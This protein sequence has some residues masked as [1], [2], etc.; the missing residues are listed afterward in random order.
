MYHAV[1]HRPER[2]HPR[3]VG[4]PGRVR[5]ADGGCS[6]SAASP[7]S[8]PPSSAAVWR[9]RRAA[10]RAA[11]P[12]HLRRRLR[13]RAP[14]R[15][16]RARQ[17]RLRGHGV[18]LHR[19][20]ARARTTRAARLDTM[21]DWDQVRE[22]AAAGRGDRRPQPHAP[23]ARPARRRA[24]CGSRLIALP[25]DRRRRTRHR[26]RLVRLPVRLLQPP[27][28]RGGARG[29]VR[30]GARRGNGLARRRQGPYALQRV[31]VRRGTRHR[32][33]RAARRGPCDRP[34]LRQGPCPHQGVRGGPQSTTGPPEGLPFPCLTRRPRPRPDVDHGRRRPSSR[35]AAVCGCPAWAGARRAAAQLF[36][37]AYALMLNTGI[38]AVLG[39]GFWLA[40]ARY[41]S[42]SA[43]GQGSAAI[44]A[45]KLLAGL[46]AV[47]L[48]GRAGPLHPGRGPGH[49][50]AHLPYVRGQFGDRGA[51]PRPSSC[52]PWTCGGRRTASCTAR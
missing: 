1:A 27:G 10:A 20:A 31:T 29:R 6:P 51:A 5:R 33:V 11:R 41:Y 24:R 23:A 34:E 7:R 15:P 36:R 50:A 42:E 2:R 32:G 28:A 39:L 48:T 43:V 25:G 13:G 40:A 37:N 19:L 12:D 4:D 22:L 14:A 17:A 26:A 30:P 46:T 45:M 52:S 49:R 9:D 16:A 38:S 8:R 21:L 18:R 44:A 47:T 3:A 35:P